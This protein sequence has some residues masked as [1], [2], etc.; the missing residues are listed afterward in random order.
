VGIAGGEWQERRGVCTPAG[1][2]VW[3]T[4]QKRGLFYEQRQREQKGEVVGG[5]PIV[6]ERMGVLVFHG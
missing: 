4:G 3:K 6:L 2:F 5:K 1:W